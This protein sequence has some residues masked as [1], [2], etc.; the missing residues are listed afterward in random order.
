VIRSGEKVH[1]VFDYEASGSRHPDGLLT[2]K[3]SEYC[4][5]YTHGMA[6]AC[7]C[8]IIGWQVLEVQRLSA[9][10]D[11]SAWLRVSGTVNSGKAHADFQPEQ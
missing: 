6:L 8:C 1:H 11:K 3:S 7:E 10:R 2:D 9:V 4:L 5:Q